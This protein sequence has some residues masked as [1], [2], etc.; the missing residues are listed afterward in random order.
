MIETRLDQSEMSA[1][2][3]IDIII[4]CYNYGRFLE[5]C[6]QS[7]LDQKVSELRILIIDDASTDDSLAVARRIAAT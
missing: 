5:R 2:A 6:V 4:P 1:M 3:K 7:V